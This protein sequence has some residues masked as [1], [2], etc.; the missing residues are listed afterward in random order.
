LQAPLFKATL[1]AEAILVWAI[2]G[3]AR[4]TR[5]VVEHAETPG[6]D[7]YQKLTGHSNLRKRAL[8]RDMESTGPPIAYRVWKS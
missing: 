6:H 8:A 1:A 2:P 7:G 3:Q 4:I 5:V